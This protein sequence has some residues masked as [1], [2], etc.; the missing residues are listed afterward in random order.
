VTR[1]TH[2]ILGD[3]IGLEL[4]R[5]IGRSNGKLLLYR[6]GLAV[7]ARVVFVA[8]RTTGAFALQLSGNCRPCDRLVANGRHRVLPTG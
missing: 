7:L 8:R 6:A 5:V 2:N 4:E 1:S 3:T